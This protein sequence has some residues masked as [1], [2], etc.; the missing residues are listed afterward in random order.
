M[1]N[2]RKSLF[3]TVTELVKDRRTGASR[4]SLVIVLAAE[5]VIFFRI[6]VG[7]RHQFY[8][9]QNCSCKLALLT[10]KRQ[11]RSLECMFNS[12]SVNNAETSQLDAD[13]GT[14]NGL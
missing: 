9:M 10:W 14:I 5:I 13:L 2:P 4:L 7:A 6:Y 12:K 1:Q 11:M 8:S 3:I